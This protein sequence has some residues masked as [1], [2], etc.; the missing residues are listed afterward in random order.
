MISTKIRKCEQRN[1]CV[2]GDSGCERHRKCYSKSLRLSCS[3]FDVIGIVK[4]ME[5]LNSAMT[6]E[7]LIFGQKKNIK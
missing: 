1:G 2:G 7:Y 5:M 4:V 6:Q 3:H